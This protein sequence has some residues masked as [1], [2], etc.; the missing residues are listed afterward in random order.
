MPL[1]PLNGNLLELM[2][3][4]LGRIVVGSG[5]CLHMSNKDHGQGLLKLYTP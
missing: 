3:L 2:L 4:A 1:S 5:P